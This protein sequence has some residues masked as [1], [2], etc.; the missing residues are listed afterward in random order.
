MNSNV[1]RKSLDPV[2]A[3]QSKEI[4][5]GF[6]LRLHAY[7][8]RQV[9]DSLF[10]NKLMSAIA[11][12]DRKRQRKC[13]PLHYTQERGIAWLISNRAINQYF[14]DFGD[15]DLNIDYVLHDLEWFLVDLYE[16]FEPHLS[17]SALERLFDPYLEKFIPA[18]T[19][20]NHLQDD[21]RWL[22]TDGREIAC[23]QIA[24][25]QSHKIFATIKLLYVDLLADRLVHDRQI[26]RHV[27]QYV[28][29]SF[30]ESKRNN[31]LRVE[32]VKFPAFVSRILLLRDKGRCATCGADLIFDLI[33]EKNIDH[34]VPLALGGCNDIIN[35]Q[36]LCDKCNSKKSDD[37]L[38]TT[39]SVPAYHAYIITKRRKTPKALY[40]V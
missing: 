2:A 7:C 39:P 30:H 13:S 27:A 36:I 40:K 34:I 38:P 21:C 15:R 33:A 12:S 22:V 5:F 26:A 35:L 1:N 25:C 19:S 3:V 17:D 32:R 31:R 16:A 11:R 20:I 8:L 18:Y 6:M 10:M 4:S 14:R 29:L 24:R 23:E 9:C 37:P 28:S